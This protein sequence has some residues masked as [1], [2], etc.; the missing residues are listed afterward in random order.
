MVFR[1]NRPGTYSSK[2]DTYSNSIRDDRPT[3]NQLLTTAEIPL[4]AER[5][6]P[7]I[8]TRIRSTFIMELGISCHTRLPLFLVI[9]SQVNSNSRATHKKKFRTYY[10][11][12]QVPTD[13][14]QGQRSIIAQ[15]PELEQCPDHERKVEYN[16][17]SRRSHHHAIS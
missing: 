16:I 2:V 3:A 14:Y 13:Q 11:L 8:L 1:S 9:N 4:V 5:H 17:R 10:E 15:R 6:G 7:N 12:I